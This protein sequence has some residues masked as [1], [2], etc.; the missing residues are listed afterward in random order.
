MKVSK[1]VLL[2]LQL[3]EKHGDIDVTIEKKKM[4][5]QNIEDVKSANY[6]G[7]K[8]FI[9]LTDIREVK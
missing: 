7:E 6:T 4:E 1:L 5:F 9:I 8:P 3:Q 2:L